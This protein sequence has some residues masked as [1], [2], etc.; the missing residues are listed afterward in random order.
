MIQ[1][2]FFPVTSGQFNYYQQVVIALN[3]RSLFLSRGA[4]LYWH[5]LALETSIW[6]VHRMKPSKLCLD[7]LLA[8]YK[9]N[10]STIRSSPMNIY[11]LFGKIIEIDDMYVSRQAV[12]SP[13]ILSLHVPV[14]SNSELVCV[15]LQCT[16]KSP[17]YQVGLQVIYVKFKKAKEGKP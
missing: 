8:W 3:L 9:T 11:L 4:Y 2:H 6:L 15:A 5:I 13:N 1:I 10:V 14:F 16:L 17:H 7:N 12:N